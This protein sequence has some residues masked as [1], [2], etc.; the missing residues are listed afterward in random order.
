MKLKNLNKR[1]QR[2]VDRIAKDTKK[3]A[4]LR[5][6][7]AVASKRTAKKPSQPKNK[8]SANAKPVSVP[9]KKKRQLS[10]EARAQLSARMK[11]RWEAKRAASSFAP[12]ID[13]DSV[14]VAGFPS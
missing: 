9:K 7:H 4:K 11:E 6:K 12:P 1:I 5:R 14:A 8:I 3:L 13:A 10:P 2:L